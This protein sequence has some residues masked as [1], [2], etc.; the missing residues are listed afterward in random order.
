VLVHVDVRRLAGGLEQ[1][2]RAER[3][4]EVEHQAVVGGAFH[5]HDEAR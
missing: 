4:V 5:E 2:L 1:G 3:V